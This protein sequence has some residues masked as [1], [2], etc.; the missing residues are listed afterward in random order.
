[1]WIASRK[2]NG[3]LFAI[4]YGA[5][6]KPGWNRERLD[7]HEIPDQDLRQLFVPVP[8][9]VP[10]SL[11]MTGTWPDSV[12]LRYTKEEETARE[13][14]RAALRAM[15]GDDVQRLNGPTL[16]VVRALT[17]RLEKLERKG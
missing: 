9:V 6:P 1:M 8:G 13:N 17:K 11:M 7:I 10:V 16:S 2:G 5:T 3:L 4:S 14:E 12:P 15:L